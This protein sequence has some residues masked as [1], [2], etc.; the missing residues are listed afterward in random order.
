M[1]AEAIQRAIINWDMAF[2][3]RDFNEN[4]K[5]MNETLLDI[6][7][8][9]IPNKTSKFDYKKPVWMNEEIRLFLKERLKLTTKY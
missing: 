9:F 5:I 4:I 6:F 1:N 7:N 8:N 2:Q 3:N